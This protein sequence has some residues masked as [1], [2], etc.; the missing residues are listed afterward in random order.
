[1]SF[2]YHVPCAFDK[3]HARLCKA[4][5]FDF[6]PA[7]ISDVQVFSDQLSGLTSHLESLTDTFPIIT[8]SGQ[9][10]DLREILPDHVEELFPTQAPRSG[11]NFAPAFKVM[12]EM[13]RE[14]YLPGYIFEKGP[15]PEENWVQRTP[16][17]KPAC[18][19]PRVVKPLGISISADPVS[20]LPPELESLS[21]STSSA[22]APPDSDS[23]K[24]R[25]G[26]K[27]RHATFSK[28]PRKEKS[29]KSPNSETTTVPVPQ[30]S[31]QET[32]SSSSSS[33]TDPDWLP[34][35]SETGPTSKILTKV[36]DLLAG[37]FSPGTPFIL[38]MS[39]MPQQKIFKLEK[40]LPNYHEDSDE[41]QF[42]VAEDG[43]IKMKRKSRKISS[44]SHWLAAMQGLGRHLAQ[45]KAA[46]KSD[47]EFVWEDFLLYIERVFSFFRAYTF[48]SVLQFDV[49]FRKWR[50][51]NSYPWTYDNPVLRDIICRVKPETTSDFFG[52]RSRDTG[53]DSL[54]RKVTQTCRNFNRPS[55]CKRSDC[56][57][58]HAC[59]DC[60][61]T[62]HAIGDCPR[63]K[64][65]SKGADGS[66]H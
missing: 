32:L 42:V 38:N 19:P 26:K 63:Q 55:G 24:D 46:G 27:L 51:A 10:S 33:D 23:G 9:V 18:T 34:P 29:R 41:K 2:E 56:R 60:G 39:P 48:E 11:L 45:R 7:I 58:L 31:Q 37:K 65:P 1:M 52:A 64:S 59:L 20:I 35:D 49:A 66:Q 13:S 5:Q 6:F 17:K 25:E 3:Y 54:S 22:S 44:Q 15:K 50:R 40:Y 4:L 21:G 62:K 14:G 12:I 57:Y 36:A 47:A 61:S 8:W 30:A 43:S 28:S 53:S 16:L